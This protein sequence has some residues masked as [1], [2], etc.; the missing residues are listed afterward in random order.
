MK[1]AQVVHWFLPKH[2][3]GTEVYT[4]RLSQELQEQHQ[5]Y[6]YCRESGFWG[7]RLHEVD[8]VY[9][10]LPVRRVYSN[11]PIA[12]YRLLARLLNRFRS[13][14]I[15][16]SFARFLDEKQPDIVHVQH[17]LLLSGGIIAVAKE[18]DLPVVV[19]LHDYWFLCHNARLLR[20]NLSLCSG[21]VGGWRCAGCAEVE[22]P[23]TLRHLLSP[24]ITPLFLYR[25]AY[26]RRHLEMADLIISP[27]AF[28]RD[29]FVDNGFAADRIQVSD[30][31]TANTWVGDFQP[32]HSD[33]LRL[34]YIGALMHH[35]GVHT[36]IEAFDKLGDVR[37]ELHV[38]GDPATSPP[39][40]TR[41]ERMAQNPRIHFQ[42]RF[43]NDEID[44][45][46]GQI[47]VLV[48]PSL[49]YEN[50]PVTIHEARLAGIPVIGARIGGIPEFVDHDVSGLLFAPGDVGDLRVQMQRL[51]D[52]WRLLERLR[53]G[54]RPVK[55][56]EENAHEL[57]GA[58]R[59][60]IAER[61][62]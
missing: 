56:I 23:A 53:Q 49:W 43:D 60:L 50:A 15:E 33:R 18:R 11:P 19:T 35:K 1:I 14:T 27:S 24:L 58:Y 10:G 41:I 16:A 4:Y 47:D 3:A 5:V 28:V 45:V 12:R 20:P 31:G 29:R 13:P 8:E 37:A 38:F 62:S 40:Y 55:S 54:V 21:P 2:L 36:L 25:T 30:N 46:L 57:E 39:Y 61:H 32:E 59:R 17:L 34:G 48:V 51:L 7:R 42:G 52:E 9:Q 26:L 22:I 44:R 6:L